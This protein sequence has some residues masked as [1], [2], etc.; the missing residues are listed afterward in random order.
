MPIPQEV[1]EKRKHS[2]KSE[3]LQK[4]GHLQ[5]FKHFQPAHVGKSRILYQIRGK[6]KHKTFNREQKIFLR[7]Y[8]KM[9]EYV[10]NSGKFTFEMMDSLIQ[11]MHRSILFLQKNK[12]KARRKKK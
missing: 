4:S 2:R 11:D 6:L 1:I 5:K 7:T 8:S 10:I 12:I 3:H 9:S